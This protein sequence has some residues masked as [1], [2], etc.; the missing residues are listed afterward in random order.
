MF[1]SLLHLL[2]YSIIHILCFCVLLLCGKDTRVY[3]PVNPKYQDMWDLLAFSYNYR[4]LFH[5]LFGQKYSPSRSICY[6]QELESGI[7]SSTVD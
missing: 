2:Y 6:L 7:R 5:Q 1:E 4:L 3:S